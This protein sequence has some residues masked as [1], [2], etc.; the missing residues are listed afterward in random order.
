MGGGAR[1]GDVVQL[2]KLTAVVE[3][4]VVAEAVKHR[5]HPPGEALDLP[6][7]AETGGGI[8]V[9]KSPV[10]RLVEIDESVGQDLDV[11]DGEI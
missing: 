6:D 5:C 10:A 2:G 1:T 3:C 9:E 4:V 8:G 7:T 11:G